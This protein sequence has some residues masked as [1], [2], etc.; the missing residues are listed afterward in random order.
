MA[1]RN[2]VH[3]AVALR[4]R[5]S[6][7]GDR[8][9]T[10]MTRDAGLVDAFVF[11]GA[12]SKI[13]SLAS[14]YV[15]GTAFIYADPVKDYRT[16]RDFEAL[17][18]F[19]GLRESLGRLW[20]ASVA[21]EMNLRTSV[22]GGENEE[23]MDLLLSVLRALQD[24]G[25]A[26]AA[27]PVLLF[28]WRHLGIMGLKPDTSWCQHCGASL[29]GVGAAFLDSDC[30]GFACEA[31]SHEGYSA[32]AEYQSAAPI[33]APSGSLAWL[34][35]ADAAF[36]SGGGFDEALR[37]RADPATLAGLKAV[38]FALS[39]RAAEGPLFSLDAMPG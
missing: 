25:E 13:R 6:P 14:P 5:E 9:L 24:S 32:H 17:E 39:R 23:A 38:V 18:V 1:E 16:L 26:E 19:P 21:A 7:A 36:S 10:F 8:I 2:H 30:E 33:R 28:L 31:C 11:G 29:S 4:A 37:A 35:R 15:H 34:R 22:P 3:D 27:Y 12:K 20:G